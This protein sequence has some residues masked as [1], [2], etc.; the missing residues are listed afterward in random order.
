LQEAQTIQGFDED[1]NL[2]RRF[3]PRVPFDLD[4]TL[5]AR[6]Q[7]GGVRAAGSVHAHP[8]PT[9]HEADDIVT[10][11]RIAA[12]CEPNQDVI[13]SLDDDAAPDDSE[14]DL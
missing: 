6:E 11:N 3:A 5:G 4:D 10:G 8:A 9:S 2:I 12:A 1:L 13:D 7:L 14:I